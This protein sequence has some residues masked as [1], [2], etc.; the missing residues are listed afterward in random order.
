L[1]PEQ[2]VKLDDYFD[3]ELLF[4]A[5]CQMYEE[6]FNVFADWNQRQAFCIRVMGL[7]Q[8]VLPPETAKV[9]CEGMYCVVNENWPVGELA[10]S[11]KLTDGQSFYRPS[12]DSHCGLG[13]EYLCLSAGLPWDVVVLPA[14]D[15]DPD[16][17]GMAL[18]W[19]TFVVQKR[20]TWRAYEAAC[21]LEN[22]S[23]SADV[24]DT[25]SF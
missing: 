6:Q 11:L 12:R 21:K 20:D 10:A 18:V 5:V 7:I 2:A 19:K 3:I 16:C 1:L 15:V 9:L 8:S 25:L 24:R 17:C 23:P 13:F 22:P 14:A 4:Y